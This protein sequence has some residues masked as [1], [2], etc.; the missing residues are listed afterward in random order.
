MNCWLPNFELWFGAREEG[1]W[2]QSV[3]M[4]HRKEDLANFWLELKYEN[5]ILNILLYYYFLLPISTMCRNLKVFF[6][7]FWSNSGFL[8]I[9]I[10]IYIASQKRLGREDWVVGGGGRGRK[11]YK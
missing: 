4:N 5:K 1:R 9:Y 10:Y 11:P 3:V 6:L 7:K 8:A 2:G